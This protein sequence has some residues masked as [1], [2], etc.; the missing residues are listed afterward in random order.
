MLHRIHI[1]NFRSCYDTNVELDRTICALSGRNG[2]GK[3]NIFKAIQWATASAAGASSFTISP[4]G[5]R[6][7]KVDTYSIDLNFTISNSHYYYVLQIP[8]HRHF[9]L[10][11]VIETT[12]IITESLYIIND[13]G[14]RDKIMRRDGV[15]IKIA[16]REEPIRIQRR[17]P[18]ISAL[19]SLLP[20]NSTSLTHL[21]RVADYF[22]GVRYYSME[23][24]S[25]SEETVTEQKYRD[26]LFTYKTDGQC[27]ES[28][29]LRLIYMFKEE[30]SLAEEFMSIIGPG[31]IGLIDKFDVSFVKLN[32]LHSILDDLD[33]S[34]PTQLYYPNFTPSDTMGGAGRSFAFPDLSVGTRR[35]IEIITSLLFD[36][37]SVMLWEH[38]EDSIHPGLLRKLIDILRTYSSKTQMIFT[39]HSP[40]VLDILAP[41]EVLLVTAPGGKTE[42]RK[43][44]S[45]E[46]SRAKKFLSND[47]SLSE[48]LEPIDDLS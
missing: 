11:Y 13:D 25:D 36:K 19:I 47:G 9:G 16:D 5:N 1:Q 32:P 28:V 8:G 15:E 23:N 34:G 46:I 37:R 40:E 38:P 39:T 31:G 20:E 12:H 17:T 44:S 27:T 29:A 2:A 42:A 41:E 24:S 48:F 14:N 30:P 3:S 4:A 21:R 10:P 18:A 33:A 45:I 43:L 26:W 6:G 22:S 35:V 7:Q